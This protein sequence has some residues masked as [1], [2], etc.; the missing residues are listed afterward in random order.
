MTKIHKVVADN[1]YRTFSKDYPV[2]LR[3]NPGDSVSTKTVCSGG[4]DLN[5]KHVHEPGNPLTGPFFV[6]EAEP[7]DT[8][9][10]HFSKIRMNRTWGY[11]SYRLGLY[12]LTPESIENTYSN[13]YKKDLIRKDR[14]DLISWDLDLET[15]MVRLDHENAGNHPMEFPANPML[16]CVGVAPEGDFRPTSGPSGQWGGNIDYNAIVEESTVYLPV[17]QPGAFL[18][19]GDGHALQGDGEPLGTG[20]ETSMDV[21]F[22]VDIIK[23]KKIAMPRLE[24]PQFISSIG[25][26]PE[27]ASSLNRGLQIATTEMIGWLTDDYK[28][29]PYSA[30]LLI[31]MVGQYKVVTVA[32]SMALQIEKK[33]LP[34][35]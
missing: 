15:N 2:L 31:G 32:G 21:E 9:K 28:M 34:Q 23:N 20:I 5:G 1:Y 13:N 25:S 16:G 27:F 26:Q 19:V 10:V 24:T 12:A 14:S 11:T 29:E 35:I 4:Q 30:H 22:S 33:H 6:D 18:Y 17:F 7:G 3:V 8:L